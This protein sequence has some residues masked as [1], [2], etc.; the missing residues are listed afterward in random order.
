MQLRSNGTPQNI[1]FSVEI[2]ESR[3]WRGKYRELED[4]LDEKLEKNKDEILEGMVTPCPERCPARQRIMGLYLWNMY[5]SVHSMYKRTGDPGKALNKLIRN[6]GL[7]MFM[8]DYGHCAQ[9]HKDMACLDKMAADLDF[10]AQN[11]RISVVLN[12]ILERF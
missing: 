4:E 3:E 11:N 9:R 2:F 8:E 1:E 10:L 6:Y 12:S 7:G 5:I